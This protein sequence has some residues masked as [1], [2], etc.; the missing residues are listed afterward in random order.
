[1]KLGVLSDTH[2]NIPNLLKALRLFKDEG[3]SQLLHC[4]DMADMLTARQ[5][6]GFDV[7]Y[8]NGNTDNSA[9][10]VSHI[11]WT[12]NPRNEIPGEVFTGELH[13]VMIAATHGHLARKLD[14]LIRSGHYTYVFH[15]HTHRKRD[16]MVGNTRVINP[17]ALGGA[18]YEP[19]TVCI[20]DLKNSD[21]R[22]MPVSNW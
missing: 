4:G 6:T 20:V 18:R 10:A 13:G 9:E 2:N 5:F 8:V 22:F 19:R 17:G 11:V 1:M 7:I 16:E 3:V 14:K 21:V 12:L 15:G